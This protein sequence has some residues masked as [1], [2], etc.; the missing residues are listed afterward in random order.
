MLLGGTAVLR[1]QTPLLGYDIG[2]VRFPETF[3]KYGTEL[4]L[5]KL[6]CVLIKV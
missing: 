5:S 4:L 2:G 1:M 3:C 6:I